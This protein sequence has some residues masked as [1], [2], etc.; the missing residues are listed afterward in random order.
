VSQTPS[1]SG[2]PPINLDR[3][4]LSLAGRV[5]RMSHTELRSCYLCRTCSSG[6]PFFKAMDYGPHGVMRLLQ[7]GQREELLACNTIWLCVGCHTCSACCPMAIDIAAVMDALRRLAL[8]DGAP[9]AEPGV[10]AFHQ[11]VLRAI[12]H[13]GRTHKLEIMLRYKA[14]QKQWLADF[15]VGLKMLAKRKLHLLPS[16]IKRPQE[17]KGLFNKPWRRLA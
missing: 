8:G 6:C 4:S 10:L 1:N 2:P 16:K 17:M 14:G 11:E 5:S 9:V 7:L 3:A 12:E 13:Y 15:D